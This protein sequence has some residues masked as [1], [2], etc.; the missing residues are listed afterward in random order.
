[1]T[2]LKDSER[3]ARYHIRA[4]DRALRLLSLLSDGKTRTSMEISEGIRLSP[5][6]TFRILV[7]LASHNFVIR[8]ENNGQYRLGLACLQLAR[9]YQDTNDIRRVALPLL[10]SLRDDIKETVHLAILDNMEVAYLEKLSGLHAI[11]IMSSRVGGRAP[12]YCT[13]VGKIL[14]A[15]QDPQMVEEHF[16]T[17]GLNRYTETT[18]TD[19]LDLM[20][21][22]DATRK[23]GY[24]FD[25]GE[26]EHEVRCIAAPIFDLNGKAVA[27]VS[28]SGPYA[29]LDPLEENHE[30]IEKVIRTGLEISLQSG[31][32]PAENNR[33]QQEDLSP[34]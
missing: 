27:A 30:M 11:G 31:Y 22:L 29:R 33:D 8:N 19:L 26:H 32:R 28:V 2:N 24:S 34:D 12:A 6:T 14:L 3:N 25:N 18:I 15:Y 16:T 10:E 9:G 1:M 17:Y 7:T 21:E 20:G 5:S 4:L 13:G 23:R